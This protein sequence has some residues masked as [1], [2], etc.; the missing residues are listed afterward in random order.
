[1]R[2]FRKR[3]ESR[4]RQG[5]RRCDRVLEEKRVDDDATEEVRG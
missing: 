3:Q 4:V 5:G 1:M 2:P